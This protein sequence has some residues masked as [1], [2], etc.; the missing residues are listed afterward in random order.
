MSLNVLA[1][2]RHFNLHA[3]CIFLVIAFIHYLFQLCLLYL[4]FTSVVNPGY[5]YFGIF[6]AKQF[7]CLIFYLN[8]NTTR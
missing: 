6:E 5:I 1:T 8:F 3:F 7:N 2:R 4:Y